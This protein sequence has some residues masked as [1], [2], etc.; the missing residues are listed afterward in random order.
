MIIHYDEYGK[1]DFLRERTTGNP[2]PHNRLC[3][4]EGSTLGHD[5]TRFSAEIQ[6]IRTTG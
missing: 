2:I 4:T 6:P 5:G 1:H 3:A